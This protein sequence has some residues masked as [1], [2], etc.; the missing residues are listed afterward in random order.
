MFRAR[1]A[2]DAV[3]ARFRADDLERGSPSAVWHRSGS[4]AE[5]VAGLLE[6][7]PHGTP[8]GAPGLAHERAP[9]LWLPH[10]GTP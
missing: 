5:V 10:S 6:L 1:S 9:D 4:V 2:H 7:P 8:G 3:G